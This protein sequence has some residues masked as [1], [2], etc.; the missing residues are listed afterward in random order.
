MHIFVTGAA[1]FIASNL[2]DRLHDA[3]HT[4]TAYDN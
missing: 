3:G 1:G 4:V 2:F